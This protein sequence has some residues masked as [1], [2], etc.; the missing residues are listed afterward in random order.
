MVIETSV[1]ART[2][3]YDTAQGIY[4]SRLPHALFESWHL[5]RWSICTPTLRAPKASK[6]DLCHLRFAPRHAHPSLH[7]SASWVPN[8]P[9]CETRP[10]RIRGWVIFR[11]S[12]GHRNTYPVRYVRACA[13]PSVRHEGVCPREPIMTWPHTVILACHGRP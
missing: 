3:Q 7:M 13:S 5:L 2:V 12:V 8:R 4:S 11:A 9:T 1:M 10:F 6:K